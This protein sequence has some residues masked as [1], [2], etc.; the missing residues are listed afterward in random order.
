MESYIHNDSSLQKI[1]IKV[2]AVDA[3]VTAGAIA[4]SLE[5]QPPVWNVGCKWIDVALEAQ[6]ALLPARQKHSIHASVGRVARRAAFHLYGR[7]LEYKR[8]ALLGMALGASLPSALSKRGAIGSAMRVVAIGTFHQAFRHAVMGRQRE[9]RLNVAVA[10]IAEFRLGFFQQTAVQPASLLGQPG[11]GEE[12]GLRHFRACGPR[13][14][15][16]LHQVRRMAVIA[17]YAV[18]RVR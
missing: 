10:S 17:G 9:L 4:A 1:D 18:H 14:P 5:T 2:G 16:R 8:P 3:G 13:I 6:Q 7:V 11:H 12:R 15:R